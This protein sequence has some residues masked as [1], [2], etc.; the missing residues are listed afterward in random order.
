MKSRLLIAIVALTVLSAPV[1]ARR[2]SALAFAPDGSMAPIELCSSLAPASRIAAAASHTGSVERPRHH[3]RHH[4]AVR[5]AHA[6]AHLQSSRGPSPSHPGPAHRSERRAALPHV[7]RDHRPP[8]HGRSGARSLSANPETAPVVTISVRGLRALE[9]DS[10]GNFAGDR[11]AGR[12]PPRASPLESSSRVFRSADAAGAF[13]PPPPPALSFPTTSTP[14][15]RH[16]GLSGAS[17][18]ARGPLRPA[19]SLTVGCFTTGS[20]SCASPADRVEG[21]TAGLPPPSVGGLT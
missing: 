5:R 16:P 21:A 8:Q 2:A 4:A 18:H 9:H 13:D 17:S 7:T 14:L 12:G 15:R 11:G 3:H 6:T 10:F 20:P 1:A 19:A